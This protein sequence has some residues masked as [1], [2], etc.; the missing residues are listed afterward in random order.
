MEK[1]IET[2]VLVIGG[3]A[4]GTG[5][6]RDLSLRGVRV[7]LI[8]KSD[9]NAG[10]S[11]A[12][13]GL[14][15]S[16]ARYVHSDIEA[17]MECRSEGLLLKQI[18]PHCIEETGGLFV[19]VPGDDEAYIADFPGMCE[20]AGIPCRPLDVKDAG[21]MEP[22]LSPLLI[23][24]FE[25]ADAAIDP[26]KLSIENMNHSLAQ[27]GKYSNHSQLKE[28]IR[29]DRKIIFARIL[30]TKTNET[31]RIRADIYISATGAW[32]GFVAA[33]AGVDIP[34]VY[35]KGSLLV[36][37]QR[38][39]TRV[40]NRLR[41]AGDADIL[42][43][44]GVVSII[45]TTSL[46]VKSPDNIFPS[47]D[48]VDLIINQGKQM[49]PDLGSRRYIRAYC[50]VRPLIGSG[51]TDDRDLSRGFCLLDHANDGVENFITITGGKLTTFRLMAEKT[52]DLACER[53]GLP[54]VCRT[55]Y[56]ALPQTEGSGWTEP[57]VSLGQGSSFHG[58]EEM[59]CECEM[60][61]ASAIDAIVAG[62]RKNRAVPDLLSIALRS[63]MGKGP[64]Q[65]SSCS[66]RVLSHLY[67]RGEITGP[68]GVDGLRRFLNERWKGERALLWGTSLAQSSL[69]E[70]IHC[71]LF[72]L[73]LGQGDLP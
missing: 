31:S 66:L 6:A 25:V 8:E 42:V 1:T 48:E 45:G 10:A 49:V 29:K 36:T 65:G 28:F 34:M 43:P 16:G 37:G 9:L 58:R 60:V 63:R 33:M 64:C 26:F 56:L 40:I 69:K 39:A 62:I 73:E 71:G 3:G 59:M 41:Q 54:S 30:D 24:A 53:L 15:H 67:N 61:P 2:Q 7:I 19:A 32:A 5:I 22:C 35:S 17:A 44:G 18:A 27:G 52:S 47:V 72:C 4:T 70:M 46:R 20:R 12:N 51:G 14:L 50:G 55:R 13:H 23:A 57:G 11:G 38:M 21:Q 68:Q